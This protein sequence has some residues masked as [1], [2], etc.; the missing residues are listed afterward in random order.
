MVKSN[1]YQNN[2]VI[3]NIHINIIYNIHFL[4]IGLLRT[5]KYMDKNIAVYHGLTLTHY[6]MLGYIY[7]YMIYKQC[8][9]QI[10]ASAIE[11]SIGY[12]WK[13]YYNKVFNKDITWTEPE[14]INPYMFNI[15][16]LLTDDD[17]TFKDEWLR[18]I[19]LQKV[20]CIDHC[21]L[22][23]RNNVMERICTRNFSYRNNSCLW[24][25]PSYTGIT[26]EEKLKLLNTNKKIVVTCIGIQNLPPTIEFLK[27]LF[28]NFNDIDFFIISRIV[29]NIII[30]LNNI[31]YYINCPVNVMFDCIKKS[32]YILCIHRDS[33][34][35]PIANS[36]SAAIPLSFSYYCHLILPEIWQEYYKFNTCIS[37]KD[38][39]RQKNG[40][41]ILKLSI[42]IPID[43]ID[44]EL[45]NIINHRN[46][47]FDN[48]F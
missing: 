14:K 22:V 35:Y 13:E 4:F 40:S 24:A 44:N 41:T 1:L 19:G 12:Y 43:D 39:L 36:I 45:K 32:N 34:P 38:N 25:L 46:L 42:D 3:I 8:N 15:I 47:T 27:S 11:G 9:M 20:I 2:T 26:K 10:F 30:D 5:T 29:D 6:E 21:G 33:N 48:F 16:I 7:D 23:R 17:M 18:D 28:L 31:H 37:Y